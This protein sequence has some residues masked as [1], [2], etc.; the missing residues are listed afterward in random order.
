MYVFIYLCVLYFYKELLSFCAIWSSAAYVTLGI[1]IQ[2][3][4]I[5]HVSLQVSEARSL[6]S[7]IETPTKSWWRK[8]TW[9]NTWEGLKE[10]LPLHKPGKPVADALFSEDKWVLFLPGSQKCRC[11]ME[12]IRL[13]G[14][15][16]DAWTQRSTNT[17][18]LNGTECPQSADSASLA[19]L[20]LLWAAAPKNLEEI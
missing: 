2:S 4:T 1:P 10:W 17:W 5:L 6:E 12:K 7:I 19:I 8:K 15:E 18:L 11:L 13:R 3:D 14:V 9:K 16:I 20:L